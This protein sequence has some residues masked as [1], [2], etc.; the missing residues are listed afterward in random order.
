[1][2]GLDSVP[3]RRRMDGPLRGQLEHFLEQIRYRSQ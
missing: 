2:S 1:L 3:R